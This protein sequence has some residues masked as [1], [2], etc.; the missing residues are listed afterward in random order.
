[1]SLGS[2]IITGVPGSLN[3]LN[4]NVS[5]LILDNAALRFASLKIKSKSTPLLL[6]GKNSNPDSPGYEDL[7]KIEPPHTVVMICIP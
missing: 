7:L 1:M 5:A 3:I 6:A 2:F 4:I